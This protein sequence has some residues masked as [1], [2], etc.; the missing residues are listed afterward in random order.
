M[1]KE[2]PGLPKQKPTTTI[3]HITDDMVSTYI[4]ENPGIVTNYSRNERVMK[5]KKKANECKVIIE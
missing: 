5:A 1:T 4:E 2:P 3:I